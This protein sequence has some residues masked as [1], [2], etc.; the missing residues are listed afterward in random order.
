MN[1]LAL[2]ELFTDQTTVSQRF[3]TLYLNFLS[4]FISPAPP[5]P[6]LELN[7]GKKIT[8]RPYSNQKVNVVRLLIVVIVVSNCSLWQKAETGSKLKGLLQAKKQ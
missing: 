5:P 4:F 7:P 8:L 2:R 6:P 3:H 1:L